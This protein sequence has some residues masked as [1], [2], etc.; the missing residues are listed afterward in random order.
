MSAHVV[1]GVLE[2]RAHATAVE[3]STSIIEFNL[4][5]RLVDI[6]GLATRLGDPNDST[7]T[8]E[9]AVGDPGHAGCPT[10]HGD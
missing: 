10:S 8:V 2:L 5:K 3:Q 4:R 7:G 1:R 9:R 6:V